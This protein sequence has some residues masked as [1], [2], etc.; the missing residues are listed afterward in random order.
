MSWNATR[1]ENE[2]TEKYMPEIDS[3]ELEKSRNAAIKSQMLTDISKR[4]EGG[5]YIYLVLWLVVSMASGLLESSPNVLILNAALFT[6]TTLLRVMHS[7]VRA[8]KRYR[9]KYLSLLLNIFVFLVLL[10]ALHW[11]SLTAYMLATPGLQDLQYPMLL[12]GAGMAAAG[13]VV[14]SIHS[15]VR[16]LFPTFMIAPVILVLLIDFN[17]QNAL[18]AGLCSIFSIYLIVATRTVHDDYWSSVNRGVLLEER[19]KEF[20]ELSITDALTQLRNRLFFDVHYDVEWKRAARH[21]RPLAVLL[22]DLDRFKNINDTHG[23]SFGDLCLKETAFKLKQG[24]M[25]TGDI[26]ARYGGEEF[27]VMLADT[28]LEGAVEVAEQLRESVQAIDLSSGGQA[29]S[30]TC[31]IGVASEVPANSDQAYRLINRAD[32]ALYLSKSAGRNRVEVDS[33]ET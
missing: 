28:E 21:R 19:A 3:G 2:V 22:I 1:V 9:E 16:A 31:S 30:I 29:V 14:L 6:L 18:I 8:V 20:E 23:H 32:K 4:A 27:I 25:R 5:V 7:K 10:N 12:T 17:P 24:V 33:G 26:L 15:A 11:G 13:S